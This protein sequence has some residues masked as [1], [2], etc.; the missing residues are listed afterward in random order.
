MT[1]RRPPWALG[2]A[3]HAEPLLARQGGLGQL[4]LARVLE[5]LDGQAGRRHDPTIV[6]RV[7]SQLDSPVD[8]VADLQ[9]DLGRQAAGAGGRR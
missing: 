8:L 9:R 5:W 1:A 2:G 4:E 3:E 7:R 6:A